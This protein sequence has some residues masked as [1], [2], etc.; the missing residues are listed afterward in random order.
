LW[1]IGAVGVLESLNGVGLEGFP[2]TV[3]MLYQVEGKGKGS[4]E[5][6]MGRVVSKIAGRLTGGGVVC[7]ETVGEKRK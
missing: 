7:G 1:I 2:S 5:G 6:V 4:G 3:D